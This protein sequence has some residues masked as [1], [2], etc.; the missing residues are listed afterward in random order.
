M[1]LQDLTDR[2]AVL[3]AISEYDRLGRDQFLHKYERRPAVRY[4]LRYEGKFYDS[5]AILGAAH[6]FQFPHKGPLTPK[7]PHG[8]L[9]GGKQ[10]I[11]KLRE[12][13]FTV[14]NTDTGQEM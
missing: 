7:G 1:S 4:M 6:G 12:L 11:S 10:T 13:G 3:K 5:K 14:V 2:S 9:H 8:G